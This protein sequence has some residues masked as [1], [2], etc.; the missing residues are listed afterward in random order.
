MR[1]FIL[2]AV[3]SITIE[4]EAESLKEVLD[5]SVGEITHEMRLCDF[6][7]NN[8]TVVNVTEVEKDGSVVI[9]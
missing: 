6:D 4:V 3:A 2:T 1:K 8:F 9:Y 7:G 5:G